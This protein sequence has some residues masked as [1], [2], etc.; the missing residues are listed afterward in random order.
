M[1]TTWTLIFT[2]L[3]GHGNIEQTKTFMIDGFPNSDQCGG[4]GKR[5]EDKIT[6]K[7]SAFKDNVVVVWSCAK[8]N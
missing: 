7:A 1:L 6:E 2:L 4:A 8:K 5:H 3:I